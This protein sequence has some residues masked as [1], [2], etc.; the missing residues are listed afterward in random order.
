MLCKLISLEDLVEYHLSHVENRAEYVARL[1][2]EKGVVMRVCRILDLDGLSAKALHRQGI[3]YMRHIIKLGQDNYPEM[4][5]NLY[6]INA[7]WIF[8]TFWAIVKPLLTEG[9][10]ERIQ[11]LGDDYHKVLA[12]NIPL[13]HLPPM[14]GGECSSC[15]NGCIVERHPDEGMTKLAVAARAVE[16]VDV[17]VAGGVVSWEFRTA[18]KDI[19]FRVFFLPKGGD[20]R[21]LVVDDGR[22]D[23]H[24]FT[25]SGGFEAPGPG[26]V[27]LQFD[28]SGSRWTAKSVVYDVEHQSGVDVEGEE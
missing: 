11:I 12:E 17:D 13:E 7:P 20:E 1:S 18:K 8:R 15:P 10:I 9:T 6:I 26:K 24:E 27:T 2:H 22:V 21:E 23:S 19:G 28:N 3:S 25:H 16:E 14:W 5:G 4:L